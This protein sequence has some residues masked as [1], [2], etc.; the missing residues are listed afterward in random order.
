MLWT[1]PKITFH[2]HFQ[3][4]WSCPEHFKHVQINLDTSKIVLDLRREGQGISN[5]LKLCDCREQQK[6][7]QNWVKF[8]NIVTCWKISGC[9]IDDLDLTFGNQL[10]IQ[11]EL[12][13]KNNRSMAWFV[14]KT[15]Q[16][17]NCGYCHYQGWP[18]PFQLEQLLLKGT[19]PRHNWKLSSC[20]L[21]L[22]SSVCAIWN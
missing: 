5:F 20:K 12:L 18:K 6:Y 4:V 14:L 8:S 11:I 22:I 16:K 19:Q 15:I 2:N 21:S 7:Q 3:N 1:R 9:D 10:Q 13:A 17:C